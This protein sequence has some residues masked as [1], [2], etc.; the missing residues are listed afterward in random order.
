MSMGVFDAHQQRWLSPEEVAG[1]PVEFRDKTFGDV[2][3]RDNPKNF[4]EVVAGVKTFVERLEGALA[5]GEGL[6]L[7]GTVGTGKTLLASLV[8]IE[9]IRLAGCMN[10]LQVE[11]H[12]FFESLKPS[13]DH[14]KR[15]SR[16]Y[17]RTATKPK[18]QYGSVTLLIIDDLG[19]EYHTDWA[20]VELDHLITSRHN[21]RLST[22]IT[23]NV[24]SAEE[25]ETTYGARIA[26]RLLERNHWY[27]LDGASY[28][29]RN[30]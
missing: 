14:H 30:K 20:Q 29:G 17:H 11:A 23:S 8:A 9:A 18:D 2:E 16:G 15:E 6:V 7:C 19:A 28:R 27:T 26:D 5:R 1:V 10:V 13:N 21:N 25:F 4:N 22:C 3:Q 24:L 12:Q